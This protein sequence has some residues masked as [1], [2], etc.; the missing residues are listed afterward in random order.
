MPLL[1]VHCAKC[2]KMIS[3][4]LDVDLETFKNLTYTERTLECPICEETQV[5]NLD[6]V[7]RSVFKKASS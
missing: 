6:D 3:T 2:R 5:W 4:G 1:H 7:D